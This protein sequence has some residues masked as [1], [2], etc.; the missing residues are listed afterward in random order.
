MSS[1]IKDD[2]IASYLLGDLPQAERERFE[3]LYVENE[4][5]FAQLLAVE[6]ELIFDYARG[7]LP[8][9]RMGQFEANFLTSAKRRERVE[10]ARELLDALALGKARE[11]EA[12]VALP[13]AS[14]RLPFLAL[15]S[16][17]SRPVLTF[18]VVLVAIVVSTL[19]VDRLRLR[20]DMVRLETELTASQERSEELRTFADQEKNSREEANRRLADQ[21]AQRQVLEQQLE[22]AR[23]RARIVSFLLPAEAMRARSVFHDV[24]VPRTATL[25]RLTLPFDDPQV[26][27]SY[28]AVLTE[29]QNHREILTQTVPR[30]ATDLERR[31]VRVDIPAELLNWGD[32]KLALLGARR[33]NLT[34]IESI[35][36]RV[37]R[38]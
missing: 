29:V 5:V 1:D 3:D 25:V 26:Y 15:I 22:D 20:R 33:S 9:E 21:L 38:R 30:S 32:Y 23:R 36:L 18:A 37:S 8:Q 14:R 16:L 13:E 17:K 34:E 28:R 11:S 27:E 7:D 31:L 12:E 6:D 35:V 10:F 19:L 2:Y 4:M 24:S